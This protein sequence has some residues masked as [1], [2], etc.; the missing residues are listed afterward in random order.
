MKLPCFL[1]PRSRWDLLALDG[2]PQHVLPVGHVRMLL[3]KVHVGG[4][5]E[6]P[7]PV[8]AGG[9]HVLQEVLDVVRGKLCRGRRKEKL[10]SG[11]LS[12]HI[13][14]KNR[15]WRLIHKGLRVKAVTQMQR[16]TSTARCA[17]VSINPRIVHNLNT[18]NLITIKKLEVETPSLQKASQ[19]SPRGFY[20]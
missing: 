3:H 15:V 11:V 6:L 12:E 10:H 9:R 20:T 2:E 17:C 16:V 7:A 14:K 8:D 5:Q 13:Q 1:F 4:Q 18:L 19:I